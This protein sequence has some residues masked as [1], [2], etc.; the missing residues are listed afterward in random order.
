VQALVN[1]AFSPNAF[2]PK[3]ID[4]DFSVQ[5]GGKN[6]KG[7]IGMTVWSWLPSI[8]RVPDP[9]GSDFF[10]PQVALVFE[11]R[12]VYFFSLQVIHGVSEFSSHNF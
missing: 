8:G 7:R 3:K 2:F 10:F 6:T 5:I 1:K 12:D 4:K 9:I 11:H